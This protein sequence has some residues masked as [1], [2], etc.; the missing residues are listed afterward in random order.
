MLLS[1]STVPLARWLHQY[2]LFLLCPN[3][4]HPSL[5]P[6]TSSLTRSQTSSLTSS[7]T[8]S[9]TTCQH[10]SL[11]RSQTR[12]LTSS[13]TRSLTCSQ[14]SSQNCSHWQ[15]WPAPLPAARTSWTSPATSWCTICQ[16]RSVWLRCLT[17]LPSVQAGWTAA[18]G[19]TLPLSPAG[20]PGLRMG[21]GGAMCS[22]R[23]WPT[24]SLPPCTSSYVQKPPLEQPWLLASSLP[25]SP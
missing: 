23:T 2:L 6:L 18:P 14:R 17:A 11:T 16:R 13:P 20:R 10:S 8:I 24:P 3:L 1:Q 15:C 22:R 4:L 25:G 12:S 5:T 19:R 7:L 9:L 21:T